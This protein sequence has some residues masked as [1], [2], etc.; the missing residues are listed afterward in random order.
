MWRYSALLS[1]ITEYS[2][3][4][5]CIH[6]RASTVSRL[7]EDVLCFFQPR[8]ERE[9]VEE[10]KNIFIQR[11]PTSVDVFQPPGR[12]ATRKNILICIDISKLT[13]MWEIIE[14]NRNPNTLAS[15]PFDRHVYCANLSLLCRRTVS[16]Y[17]DMNFCL[18]SLSLQSPICSSCGL[19]E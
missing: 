8:V 2:K 17:L 13:W 6:V 14:S 15:L 7:K 16:F 10:E 9:E 12:R 4:A 3:A 18:R 19:N 5:E 1:G 11:S